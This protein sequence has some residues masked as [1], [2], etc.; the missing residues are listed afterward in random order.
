MVAISSGASVEVGT[1]PALTMTGSRLEVL[2]AKLV[3][4]E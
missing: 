3:S 1:P 4:P 2:G